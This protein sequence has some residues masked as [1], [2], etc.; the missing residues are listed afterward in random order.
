VIKYANIIKI[1]ILFLIPS[2]FTVPL[3][4]QMTVEERAEYLQGVRD[5]RLASHSN[6]VWIAAGFCLPVGSSIATLFVR[7]DPPPEALLGK[8]QY[9]IKG[10]TRG[11]KNRTV[12]KN[13]RSTF[14][15]SCAIFVIL[16]GYDFTKEQNCIDRNFSCGTVS[17][18]KDTKCCGQDIEYNISWALDQL[19][20]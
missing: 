16:V 12:L 11:Y 14:I 17:G 15:G 19:G 3:S 10:Y 9:Y 6:I 4:A 20:M 13:L 8:S 18:T 1:L 2:I 5:G 7:P